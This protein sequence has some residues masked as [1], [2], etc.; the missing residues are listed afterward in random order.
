MFEFGEIKSQLLLILIYPVGIIFSRL[1]DIYYK[2]NPYFYLFV[3]FF[4]HLLSIIPLF[5]INLRKRDEYPTKRKEKNDLNSKNNINDNID[6][7][8]INGSI[9]VLPRNSFIEL[10]IDELTMTLEKTKKRKKIINCILI[11][12][13]YFLCYAYVYYNNLVNDSVFYGNISIITETL[14]FSL[15]NR[16]I[17]G[18]RIYSHH[19]FSVILITIS[20]IGLYII[21]MIN[22]IKNNE[23]R[24]WNDFIFPNLLNFIFYFVF[25]YFIVKGKFYIEKYFISSYELI[26][27]LG[28]IGSILLLLFE[29]ITFFIPC[30][31]PGMCNNGHL[32]GII[33]G[34]YQTN[35]THLGYLYFFIII[36]GLF[37]TALG[38]WTTVEFLSPSHFLTSDSIITFGLNILIDCYNPELFLLKNP[39]F[40]IF[41]I[42]T[43]F[44]CLVY[45]EVIII[46]ICNLNY[47]TRREIIKR[48]I[49]DKEYSSRT[50]S[51][52]EKSGNFPL[53]NGNDC[54]L[55]KDDMNE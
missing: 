51:D 52:S 10:E 54:L 28:I 20:I 19:F 23:Y 26:L 11:S 34:F 50:N 15:F 45:N 30:E 55:D 18:K 47:N 25:C 40:Y 33:S 29:P 39:L 53:S 27:Y 22:F 2:N 8:N 4:S 32:S 16:M 49:E 37:M 6:G 14:Y 3:F 42:L 38:L 12:L 17:L 31:N 46:K 13:L 24:I 5:I 43:I 1:T 36:I 48:T 9:K 7:N 44:S 21:L 35:A 41:S